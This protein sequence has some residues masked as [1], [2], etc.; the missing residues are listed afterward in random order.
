MEPP[1]LSC[2]I[3]FLLDDDETVII[4]LDDRPAS[5]TGY[6]YDWHVG[7]QPFTVAL[8]LI[9]LNL[10][11]WLCLLNHYLVYKAT[12]LDIPAF[13]YWPIPLLCS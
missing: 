4:N 8:L 6:W 5:A 10:P 2:L 9:V 1:P 7:K 3:F 11:S 12:L 13:G